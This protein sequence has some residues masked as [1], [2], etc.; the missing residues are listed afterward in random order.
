MLRWGFSC[1]W[2]GYFNEKNAGLVAEADLWYH[3]RMKR[4]FLR[5]WERLRLTVR[6]GFEPSASK[7]L[8][9]IDSPTQLPGPGGQEDF[10]GAMDVPTRRSIFGSNPQTSEA[11]KPLKIPQEFAQFGPENPAKEVDNDGER[12]GQHCMYL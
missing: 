7:R 11:I 8:G 12:P 9:Q 10:T 2:G 1:W 5:G 3:R 4:S 6:T